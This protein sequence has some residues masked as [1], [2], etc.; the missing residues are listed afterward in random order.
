MVKSKRVGG[1]GL[2]GNDK[3]EVGFGSCHEERTV[4]LF[5]PSWFFVG[6]LTICRGQS[7]C[8]SRKIRIEEPAFVR[9]MTDVT[10]NCDV[11]A[12]SLRHARSKLCIP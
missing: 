2:V 3:I 5:V 9:V 1:V 6:S 11:V 4:K 8:R 7:R 12:H 10:Q